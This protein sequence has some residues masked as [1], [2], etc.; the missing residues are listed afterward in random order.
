MAGMSLLRRVS[1][2]AVAALSGR[3]LGTR[4]GFGGFLTRGFPKAVAPV[5][6]SG[7][8]G[9]RLFVIKPSRFYDIRFLKLLRFYIALTGIPV[10]I[11][12]TL[13]N[14][15]IGEAELAEIPEG[16][17]PEHWEYYKHPISRWIA[18]NFYDS[19]EKIYEKSMAV[20]QIEAEKAELRLKELEVRRLMRMRGDGPWY[21][22]ETI[23]KELIDHSPKATPDN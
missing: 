19:P 16:Y 23:D 7:G 17:I 3:S 6:H 15:F 2:T 10:V 14:V 11:I 22:Y 9:K 20:L 8:H 4:L 1:V 21:Y 5:R 12:I 13:V 18:R